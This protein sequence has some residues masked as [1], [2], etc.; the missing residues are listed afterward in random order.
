MCARVDRV[1]T[2]GRVELLEEETVSIITCTDRCKPFEFNLQLSVCANCVSLVIE[3]VSLWL[4]ECGYFAFSFLS[5][6]NYVYKTR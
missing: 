5:F 6:T 3:K 2:H 4:C 1:R